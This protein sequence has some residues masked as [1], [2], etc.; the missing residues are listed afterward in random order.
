VDRFGV[1]ATDPATENALA[2]VV[3]DISVEKIARGAPQGVN[4]GDRASGATTASIPA[5]CASV[6]PPGR[7]VAQVATCISPFKKSSGE[8][9]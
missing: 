3:A 9:R 6:K 1:A 7:R 5:I 4:F 8:T 2:G